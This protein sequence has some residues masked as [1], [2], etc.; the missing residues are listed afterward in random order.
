[1]VEQWLDI[2]FQISWSQLSFPLIEWVGRLTR[3]IPKPL[4]GLGINHG[5][6]GYEQPPR[7]QPAQQ[8][9]HYVFERKTVM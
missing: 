5:L 1:M 2:L 3:L 6:R 7:L 9:G 4:Q 8:C